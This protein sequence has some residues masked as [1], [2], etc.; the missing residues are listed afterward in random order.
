MPD[1]VAVI[2]PKRKDC[3]YP[4]GSL[5]A[6]ALAFKV[7]QAL[8]GASYK[9]NLDLVALGTIADVVPLYGE[10][11]IFV[12]LGLTAIEKTKNLGLKALIKTARIKGKRI[13]PRFVGFILG[14]RINA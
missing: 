1:A 6:V 10:N 14:P 13:T 11:R 7:A 5:A 12:K 9:E 3:L 2:D 4:F 8:L